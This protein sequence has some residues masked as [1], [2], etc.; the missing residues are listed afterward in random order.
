MAGK[1]K[2]IKGVM[3]V[4]ALVATAYFSMKGIHRDPVEN[5]EFESSLLR[6]VPTALVEP[7]LEECQRMFPGEVR[8]NRRVKLS[9]SV[10]GLLKELNAQEGC[11]I[12][13]GDRIAMLDRRDF[14]NV[15]DAAEA[16]FEHAEREWIRFQNMRDQKVVSETRC[17]EAQ[18]VFNIA[19]ARLK[20]R[21]KALRDAELI[22][23]FDGT[24]VTRFVENHEHVQ[25]KQP[26]VSLQDIS[27]IEIVIQVP[28]RL[29]ALK[30][31]DGL[32]GLE[33]NFDAAPEQWF[34]AS[35]RE[36]G[37]EADPITRTYD[38]VVSL[39]PPDDLCVLPGM[40][41]TVLARI[42]DSDLTAPCHGKLKRIPV[43]ALWCGN[44]GQS[45][46]WIINPAGGYPEKRRVEPDVLSGDHVEIRDGLELNEHVATAGLHVLR[47]NMLVRPMMGDMEGLDG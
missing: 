10:S 26:I 41:A 44:D 40:T 36:F 14:Q 4:L 19:T 34:D 23:P 30:G 7:K 39:K 8:A 11:D 16:E 13:I 12:K 22:A 27:I 5:L 46:V 32:G 3:V 2:F 35:I 15:L 24:V 28:E 45:Y 25:V 47:E 21:K 31:I 42:T 37:S 17:D 9:F 20:I 38:V 33:V 18:A 6:P 43:E 29:I 1:N